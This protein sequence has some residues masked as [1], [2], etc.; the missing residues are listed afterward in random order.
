MGTEFLP[1]P[2]TRIFVTYMIRIGVNR[3]VVRSSG[4]AHELRMIRGS[5]VVSDFRR[6]NDVWE[7][8]HF[9]AVTDGALNY[10]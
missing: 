10:D 2:S 6:F 1:E 4:N 8:I 9:L 7:A 5:C 3:V